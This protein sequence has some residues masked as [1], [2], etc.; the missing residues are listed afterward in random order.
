VKPEADGVPGRA[1]DRSALSLRTSLRSDDDLRTNLMLMT[2][3]HDPEVVVGALELLVLRLDD[4]EG[5]DRLTELASRG[6]RMEVRQ[7][8]LRFAEEHRLDE[9][10]D[11]LSSY[12][13]DL[14][15]AATCE[16]RRGLVARLRALGDARAIPGL[17]QAVART[18]A[19]G[20]RL[21]DC[22]EED[23]EQAILY[24]RARPAAPS[25]SD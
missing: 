19:K 22:L 24:L 5:R 20:R 16:A 10:I 6:E 7:A 2:H 3:E 25:G 14:E 15:Q 4:A 21:N 23:A 1:P 11:R 13:L 18:G 17:E 12:L 9:S 8:A